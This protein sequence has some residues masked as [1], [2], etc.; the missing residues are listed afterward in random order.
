M[1]VVIASVGL[2]TAQGSVFDMTNGA[3]PRPPV[4]LPWPTG[5]WTTCHSSYGA[6]GVEPIRSGRD[7]WSALAEQALQE[8]FGGNKPSPETP[9][10]LASCNGAAAGFD[11]DNWRH[12]F[13]SQTL[14]EGSAWARKGLPLFSTSC[15]SGLHALYIARQLLL[16]GYADEV[17]VLAVDILSPASHDNFEVLRVLSDRPTPWQSASMGFMPGEAAVA[18]HLVRNRDEEGVPSLDGPTLGS[19]LQGHDGL[20]TVLS[21]LRPRRLKLILGQG[22]GPFQSD[23]LELSALRANVSRDV[24]LATPL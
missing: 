15:T 8:C 11:P 16:A 24:P 14:L 10:L 19:D 7:R 1:N 12:A 23:E 18:L 13:D 9:L 17:V 6:A 3:V 22:T 21:E 2:A 5:K 20:S 4:K